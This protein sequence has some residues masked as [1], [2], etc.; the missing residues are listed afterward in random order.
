MIPPRALGSARPLRK[1]MLKMTRRLPNL[2]KSPKTPRRTTKRKLTKIPRT[3][4]AKRGLEKLMEK[5]VS[6]V[7]RKKKV[8]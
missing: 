2:M 3:R 1:V 7:R 5:A 6:L 8:L 4:T